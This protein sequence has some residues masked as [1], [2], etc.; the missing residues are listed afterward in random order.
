VSKFFHQ[1]IGIEKKDNER[2]LNHCPQNRDHAIAALWVSMHIIREQCNP[3]RRKIAWH[4]MIRCL[5]LSMFSILR[6]MKG[7]RLS[8]QST[9]R[10][11]SLSGRQLESRESYQGSSFEIK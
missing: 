6:R 4:G 8:V 11:E 3:E 1:E 7:L 10:R 9:W 2:D 5:T